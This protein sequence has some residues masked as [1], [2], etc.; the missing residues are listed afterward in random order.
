MPRSSSVQ[1]AWAAN[2]T[3][4]R[5]L[6][7]H[8]TPAML[9]AASPGGGFTV[10]DHLA[11]ITGVVKHWGMRIDPELLAEVPDLAEEHGDDAWTVETDL[12]RIADVHGR[13]AAAAAATAAAHPE[14]SAA[15]PHADADAYLIHMLVHDAHHRGQILL[16]LKTAGHPLPDE[17]AMWAPWRS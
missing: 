9:S 5:A 1:R 14:G 6:I 12:A 10:A 8:L 2:Q 11:H 17:D 15:S 7:D 13:T 16:A 3:V 4:N